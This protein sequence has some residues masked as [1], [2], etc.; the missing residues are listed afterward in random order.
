ML[1]NVGN[2]DDV[3]CYLHSRRWQN[4]CYRYGKLCLSQP[5]NAIFQNLASNIYCIMIMTFW[6]V[7]SKMPPLQ[8]SAHHECFLPFSCH[9]WIQY[10]NNKFYIVLCL[11]FV[12]IFANSL[13]LMLLSMCLALPS[14]LWRSGWAAGRVLPF[15]SRLTR[16]VPDKI[17]EGHKT[18]LCVCVVN[19]FSTPS[20]CNYAASEWCFVGE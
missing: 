7:E 12:F 4:I 5:L 17:Q 15:W 9:H 10:Y 8:N 13:Y 19:V 16:V 20:C 6:T 3:D 11:H 1:S 2:V 18:V 14:V